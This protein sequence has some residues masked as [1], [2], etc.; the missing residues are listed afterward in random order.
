MNNITGEVVQVYVMTKGNIFRKVVT[1]LLYADGC[2]RQQDG[3]KVSE[4][5]PDFADMF[6]RM[7]A[8]GW[9]SA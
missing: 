4:L 2:Y 9:R 6:L 7:S 3:N 8:N 1:F 5:C